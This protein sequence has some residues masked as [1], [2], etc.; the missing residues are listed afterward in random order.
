MT[1]VRQ[2]PARINVG[3]YLSGVPF[4]VWT[5]VGGIMAGYVVLAVGERPTRWLMFL[6]AGAVAATVIT[7]AGQLRRQLMV[8]FVISLS[9][10]VNYYLTQPEQLLFI[11]NSSPTYFSIP[12]VLLPAFA[13]AV[14]AVLESIAGRRRIRYGF[15]LT[16]FALFVLA[17]AFVSTMASK[18]RRYG[19][20]AMAE[21]LEFIFIYLVA[22]NTVRTRRDFVLV[23]RLLLFTLAVQCTAFLLQTATGS[24]FTLTGQVFRSS[25]GVVRASGTVGVNPASYAGFIEPLLFIAFA[26]WRTRGSGISPAWTGGL[27]AVASTTLILT[28]D[29]TAWVT[30]PLGLF[31]VEILCRRRRLARPLT[32]GTQV[33]IATVA[34]LVAVG[35]TPLILP[36]LFARHSDDWTTRK[37][38]MRI[39]F[40]MIVANPIIGVGPGAYPFHIRQYLPRGIGNW[41]WVVHN[42]YLLIL[43][44]GG[45]I[46]LAAWLAWFRAGFRQALAATKTH[47]VQYQ[48]FAIGC[49]AGVVGIAWE[50]MLNAFPSFCCS[51]LL[52]FLF[53]VL[54][55]GN[56]LYGPAAQVADEPTAERTASLAMHQV[57][58]AAS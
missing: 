19:I 23:L 48:A 1:S 8:Y 33:A 10:N 18:V 57:P 58:L 32:V 38:L 40:N 50:Y 30:L 28:L 22:L 14:W 37:D 24:V 51:A 9:L 17:A 25:E 3:A 7:L 16:K 34:L 53:G 43:A 5:I 35:V 2:A 55:S 12:L 44:E 13:L 52:W 46:G 36:R 31:V 29:R 4:A 47:T 26:L 42:Q 20:Y 54:V 41:L 6:L 21:M 45:I 56:E 39:A 15:P 11:G 49:V 27:V